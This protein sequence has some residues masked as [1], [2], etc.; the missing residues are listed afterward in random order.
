MRLE[1]V[2]IHAGGDVDAGAVSPPIHLSTT[3]DARREATVETIEHIRHV[4][5]AVASPFG[6]SAR[7]Q[8]KSFGDGP[9][10]RDRRDPPRADA[11]HLRRRPHAL[12]RRGVD[13]DHD[14]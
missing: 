1:T 13:P 5:G 3:L 14:G 4:L 11:P 8:M 2:A 9:P 12:P 7:R 6:C 10:P